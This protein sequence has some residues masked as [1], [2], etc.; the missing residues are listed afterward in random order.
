MDPARCAN[1]QSQMLAETLI[2]KKIFIPIPLYLSWQFYQ[3]QVSIKSNIMSIPLFDSD[4]KLCS[5]KD[6][7]II[8]KLIENK[9]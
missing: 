3:S 7:D 1:I 5:K 8:K 2:K 6:S 4:I 9:C